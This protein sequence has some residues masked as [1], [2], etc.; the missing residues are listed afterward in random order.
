VSSVTV[1]L[2]N[3]VNTRDALTDIKD[4]V[5][6]IS[7]PEDVSDSNIQEISTS[8]E[9]LFQV[10]LYGSKQEY[11]NFQLITLARQFEND[12]EGQG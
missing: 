4:S 8:N 11:S 1:E 7:F 5:D 6:S 3:G 10:L 9:L 12:L 2:S